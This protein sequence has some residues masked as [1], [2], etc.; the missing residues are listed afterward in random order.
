M[1]KTQ[2]K[3]GRVNE[4]FVLFEGMNQRNTKTGQCNLKWERIFKLF[5]AKFSTMS[6]AVFK[7]TA[8]KVIFILTPKMFYKID[9]K[10][11]C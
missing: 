6:L 1:M 8:C 3:I 5:W 10:A 9:T 2:G 4:P 7:G 11:Q